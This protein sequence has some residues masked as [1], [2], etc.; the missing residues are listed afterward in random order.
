M[1]ESIE[2]SMRKSIGKNAFKRSFKR[3]FKR[4]FK[5]IQ[6][7]FQ[8]IAIAMARHDDDFS[9]FPL[10][11]LRG[12]HV[13][14]VQGNNTHNAVCNTIRNSLGFSLNTPDLHAIGA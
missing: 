2:E 6:E 7:I 12:R 3:A 9:Y 1:Q 10:L 11:V 5:S 14:T 8:A 13:T 4:A